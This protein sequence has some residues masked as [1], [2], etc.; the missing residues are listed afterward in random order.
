MEGLGRDGT[1]REDVREDH[2]GDP[3]WN[4]R[5]WIQRIVVR[6]GPNYK[7]TTLLDLQSEDGPE[8]RRRALVRVGIEKHGPPF[9]RRLLGE[10]V[11]TNP[12]AQL[13]TIDVELVRIRQYCAVV[14]GI[15][16]EV[17]VSGPVG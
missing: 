3:F 17:S 13:L 6:K 7:E 15:G 12:D 14:G 5:P 2:G 11:G 8:R 10:R 1:I 16:R 9:E 4:L